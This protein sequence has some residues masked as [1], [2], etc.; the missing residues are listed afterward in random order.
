MFANAA[1]T[2][3]IG[4][5][6]KEP[7]E[8][9]PLMLYWCTAA[10]HEPHPLAFDAENVRSDGSR[11]LKLTQGALLLVPTT[12]TLDRPLSDQQE[13]PFEMRRLCKSLPALVA[14][15]LDPWTVRF[16]NLS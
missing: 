9:I 2:K 13:T 1:R 3:A 16:S 7:I 12:P 10:S 6:G 4:V 15:A 8:F 5:V 14:F 11:S